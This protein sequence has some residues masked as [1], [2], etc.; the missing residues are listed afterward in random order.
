MSKSKILS[1]SK[2]ELIN[3]VQ[4]SKLIGEILQKIGSYRNG[5]MHV[6]LIARLN[7]LN[8]PYDN[9]IIKKGKEGP[10]RKVD[11]ISDDDFIKYVETSDTFIQLIHKLGYNNESVPT[12]TNKIIK[13]RMA[14]LNVELHGKTKNGLIRC[15]KCLIYKP[16]NQ[17]HNTKN[18]VYCQPCLIKRGREERFLAKKICSNYKGGKCEH[19]GYN[20]CLASLEFHHTNPDNKDFN[21]SRYVTK[22]SLNWVYSEEIPEDIKTEI[23]KCILLCSNCHHKLHF[24]EG[25][26]ES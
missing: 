12:K 1:V 2:E 25:I 11:F 4:S 15:A 6:L 18:K 26:E 10:T 21:I 24:E 5:E 17:Y 20:E 8:I 16:A 19:C 14:K 3:V 9:I 22:R 7:E 13:D 23:D